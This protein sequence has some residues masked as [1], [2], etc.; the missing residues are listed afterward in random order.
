M[1]VTQL[2]INQPF[3]LEQ[4]GL[5]SLFLKSIELMFFVTDLILIGFFPIGASSPVH[6]KQNPCP[7]FHRAVKLFV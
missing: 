1:P 3:L 2:S 7:N 4:Q 5:K 6:L